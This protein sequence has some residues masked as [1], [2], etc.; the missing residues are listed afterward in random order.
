MCRLLY[1]I[2]Y[3]HKRVLANLYRIHMYFVYPFFLSFKAPCWEALLLRQNIKQY[4]FFFWWIRR[5]IFWWI[6]SSTWIWKKKKGLILESTVLI[7]CLYM[8]ICFIS[9]AN[10]LLGSSSA[11]KV[12][13]WLKLILLDIAQATGP[14]STCWHYHWLGT[15]PTIIIQT[16][17][18][19][20]IYRYSCLSM[21]KAF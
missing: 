5:L 8:I 18:Y 19:I 14:V 12:K 17:I 21:L 6:L 9:A 4:F 3:D 15:G 2:K 13:T 11:W 16:N 1:Q 20:Y 10:I 7:N